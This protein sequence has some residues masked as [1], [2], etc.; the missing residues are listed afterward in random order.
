MQLKSKAKLGDVI[1][2]K[3]A[4]S[5]HDPR[6]TIIYLATMR[7][8]NGNSIVSGFN[9][10]YLKSFKKQKLLIKLV[11]DFKNK[12]AIDAYDFIRDNYS[13]LAQVYRCYKEKSIYNAYKI[14]LDTAK[15]TRL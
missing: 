8:Q 9:L 13:D 5:K 6:P 14:D 3:Y 15:L 12:K 4:W 1:K 7:A 11:N 10:N 2:I